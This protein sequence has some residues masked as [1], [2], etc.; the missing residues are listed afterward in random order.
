MNDIYHLCHRF[1]HIISHRLDLESV[2]EHI[3]PGSGSSEVTTL[4]ADVG[5]TVDYIFYSPRRISTSD[6]Q[7]IGMCQSRRSFDMLQL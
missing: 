7:G 5:A 1:K 2:Y 4:N 3:L 6:P